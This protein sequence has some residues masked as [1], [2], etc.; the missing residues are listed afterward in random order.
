MIMIFLWIPLSE[1]DQTYVHIRNTSFQIKKEL[2][3]SVHPVK[4][5]EVANI[6]KQTN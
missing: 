5:S 1:M 2:L 6:K 4:S 3:I